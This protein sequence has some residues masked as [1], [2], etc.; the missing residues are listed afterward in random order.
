MLVCVQSF[1]P[2]FI[3]S[4]IPFHPISFS[5]SIMSNVHPFVCMYYLKMSI[6]VFYICIFNLHKWLYV[7]HMSALCCFQIHPCYYMYIYL[8]ASNFFHEVHSSRLRVS[9]DDTSSLVAVIPH[10]ACPFSHWSSPTAYRLK[11]CS[12]NVLAKYSRVLMIP[13]LH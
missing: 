13:H 5:V 10:W 9:Y 6:V 2:S 7:I 8:V 3:H 4:F 11:P 1:I 12:V